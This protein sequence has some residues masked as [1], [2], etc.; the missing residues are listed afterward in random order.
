ME[1]LS[2]RFGGRHVVVTGGGTGI[3]R[4]IALRLAREGARLT[5]LARDPRR[6]EETAQTALGLGAP[7]PFLLACDITRRAQVEAAFERATQSQGPLFALVANA[8]V[9]GPNEPGP[10]DRFD[11]I[12]ATNLTGT[13]TCLRAAER[14]LEPGP[15]PRHLIVTASILARIGVPGYTGY[16]ASKAALLGLVRALA[17]ELAPKNIQVNAVCPGWVDTD[18]AREGLLLMA[19]AMKVPFDEARRIAMSAVP[20][21]RMSQPDEIAGLV[22]Y[23]LSPDARGLT[24]QG[25]DMNGGAFMH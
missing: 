18:M 16:C 8:G 17:A 3:G 7:R 24:G 19:D 22:A 2:Q 1:G 5:L 6:L 9:G 20:A 12:V 21:G 11:E 4:A 14:Q 23:L 25:L 13:Y 15:A 10:T